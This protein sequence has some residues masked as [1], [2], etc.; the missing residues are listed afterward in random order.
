M[1]GTVATRTG[2]S[3]AEESAGKLSRWVA[4]PLAVGALL[5]L[6]VFLLFLPALLVFVAVAISAVAFVSWAKRVVR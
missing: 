1:G 2:E 5:L 3:G 4:V 6:P